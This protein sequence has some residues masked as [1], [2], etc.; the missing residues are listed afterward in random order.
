MQS[1]GAKPWNVTFAPCAEAGALWSQG[2]IECLF[3]HAA[4]TM[5]HLCC[6]VAYGIAHGSCPRRTTTVSSGSWGSEATWTN[7]RVADA[8]VMPDIVSGHTHAPAMMIGSKAAAMI[9]ED[10]G[11]HQ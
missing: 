5:W 8:S 11:R 1:V 2:Y 7:L 9:I 10:N 4:H 3:R 6:T